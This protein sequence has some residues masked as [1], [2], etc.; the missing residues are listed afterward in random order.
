MSENDTSRFTGK[1]EIQERNGLKDKSMDDWRKL[2]GMVQ[3]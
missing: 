1:T 3:M 2:A